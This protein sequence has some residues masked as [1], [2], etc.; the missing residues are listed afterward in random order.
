MTT[1]KLI[2]AAISV[3][4]LVINS[5]IF[6]LLFIFIT[7]FSKVIYKVLPTLCFYFNLSNGYLC[8]SPIRNYITLKRKRTFAQ[9]PMCFSPIWNYITLKRCFYACCASWCFSPI[10]N[11]ITL[12]P[13]RSYSKIRYCFSP[14]WNY[15]TLKLPQ[16]K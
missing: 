9:V 14:I 11:Y 5:S 13:R 10:W 8:F 15:I 4:I 1:I 12:K 16:E 7:L 3:K 2:I 6:L